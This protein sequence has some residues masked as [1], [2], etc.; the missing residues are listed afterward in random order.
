MPVRRSDID[1]AALAERLDRLLAAYRS[2]CPDVDPSPEFMPVLWRRIEER[3]SAVT[4]FRR[5]ARG[6]ATVA[7]AACVLLGLLLSVPQPH[8][9]PF[10]SATYLDTLAED[11]STENLLYVGLAFADDG[12]L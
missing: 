7:A 1:D 2:A 11:P 10:Y 6:F 8:E 12:E 5:W 3:R 4:L 9:S